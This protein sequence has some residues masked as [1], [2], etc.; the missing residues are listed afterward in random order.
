M[1]K[2]MNMHTYI[3]SKAFNKDICLGQRILRGHFDT[4][5]TGLKKFVVNHILLYLFSSP[6]VVQ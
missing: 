5:G 4:L 1:S 6:N 3:T 2:Y